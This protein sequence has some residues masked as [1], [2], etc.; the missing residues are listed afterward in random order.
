M[1]PNTKPTRKA[2]TKDDKFNKNV[3][4]NGD[5]IGLHKCIILAINITSS[6]A[7]RDYNSLFLQDGKYV[8]QHP[9]NQ[10]VSND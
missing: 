4:K 5:P 9:Y 6:K 10:E 8:Q 1:Y 7:S 2:S 3:D